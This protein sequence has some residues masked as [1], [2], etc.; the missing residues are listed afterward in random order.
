MRVLH[1]DKLHD[2]LRANAMKTL[3]P[4]A[5]KYYGRRFFVKIFLGVFYTQ[6]FMAMGLFP[7]GF[8]WAKPHI[9]DILA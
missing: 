9:S 1:V 7:D 8:Q 5:H 2:Y 3:I 6:V 4:T